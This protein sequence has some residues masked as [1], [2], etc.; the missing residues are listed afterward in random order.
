MFGP[1]AKLDV[2]GSFHVST[3]DYLSLEDGG[4]FEVRNP[5]ASLLTVAPVASFGFFSNT[6]ASIKLQDSHLSVPEGIS[7]I[8]GD[9]DIY[10]SELE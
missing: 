6:P 1:N 2:Q 5:N 7:L 4:R 10:A 9:I 3:A 8:G